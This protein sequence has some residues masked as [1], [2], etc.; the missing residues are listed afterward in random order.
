MATIH[1]DGGGQSPGPVS[2][3]CTVELSD[4]SSDADVKRFEQGTHNTA[5]WHALILGLR[6]ALKHGERHVV[7]KGDSNTRQPRTRCA[8]RAARM[9]P[10]LYPRDLREAEISSRGGRIRTADLL[11][12][13]ERGAVNEG[14]R[15]DTERAESPANVDD[16][17]LSLW[18][19]DEPEKMS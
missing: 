1:F 8:Q 5:K 14:V 10:V 11:L 12:P 19:G 2:A 3:A 17:Q 15:E 4:G 18:T 7:V 13:N 9:Y 6:L 16:Q